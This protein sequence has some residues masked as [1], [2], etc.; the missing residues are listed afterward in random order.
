[1]RKN[2]NISELFIC[3]GPLTY[4]WLTPTRTQFLNEIVEIINLSDT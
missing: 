2:V 4:L 1:M 3:A